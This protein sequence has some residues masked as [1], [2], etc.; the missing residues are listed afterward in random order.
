MRVIVD[1]VVG[2]ALTHA[3]DQ[4]RR[5][6]TLRPT[7]L[8]L[9]V[10]ILDHVSGRRERLAVAAR[11]RHASVAGVFNVATG[12]LMTVTSLDPDAVIA[13]QSNRAASDLVGFTASDGDRI[14]ARA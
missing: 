2:N 9:E 12:N 4:H 7:A 11:Q 3:A 8:L 1:Q 13:D 6:V 10:A 5:H 14:A